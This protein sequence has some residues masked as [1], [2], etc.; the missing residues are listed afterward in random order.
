VC[1]SCS[2]SDKGKRRG[3]CSRGD[4]LTAGYR[5]MVF[6]L[7]RGA[8]AKVVFEFL[9]ASE[10]GEDLYGIKSSDRGGLVCSAVRF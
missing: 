3:Q 5:L 4:F 1:K 6:L 8:R 9:S 7:Q 10:Q 2:T